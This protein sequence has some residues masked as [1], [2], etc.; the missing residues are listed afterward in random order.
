ML[1]GGCGVETID[2]G[3]SSPKMAELY[4]AFDCCSCRSERSKMTC[5]LDQSTI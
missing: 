1:C 5:V 4:S 2:R 3:E